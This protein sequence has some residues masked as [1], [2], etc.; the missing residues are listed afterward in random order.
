LNASFGT[1]HSCTTE[2]LHENLHLGKMNTKKNDIVDSDEDVPTAVQITADAD[3]LLPS[4][5][6]FD[7]GQAGDDCEAVITVPVTLIT[8]CLGAGI[9][10]IVMT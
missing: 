1:H 6:G 4:L 10:F 9:Q 7:H 3:P 8:G 2:G 5:E